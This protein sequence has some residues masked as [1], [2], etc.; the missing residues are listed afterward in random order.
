MIGN[1]SGQKPVALGINETASIQ[2]KI[3]ILE[4][5]KRVLKK[6]MERVKNNNSLD[7]KTAESK[8]MDLKKQIE[9]IE[10]RIK[11]LKQKLNAKTDG[12][13]NASPAGKAQKDKTDKSTRESFGLPKDTY[14]KG[15]AKEQWDNIYSIVR[16]A[17]ETRIKYVRPK[18]GHSQEK[19]NQH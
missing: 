11:Q 1:V 3:E 4:Q 10:Q 18:F 7:K 9:K 2:N 14:E 12:T 5:Q 15:D 17:G 6:E 8:V 13:Q 19:E 16:E